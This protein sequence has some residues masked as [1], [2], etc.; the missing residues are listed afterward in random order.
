MILNRSF[1][2]LIVTPSIKYFCRAATHI[3]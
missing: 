3:H 2:D 1:I